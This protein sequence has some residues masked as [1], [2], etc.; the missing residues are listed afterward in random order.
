MKSLTNKIFLSTLLVCTVVI[1]GF[2]FAIMAYF[3]WFYE[4]HKIDQM[5][6]D[7]ERFSEG[8]A[9]HA[10]DE[11]TLYQ[12]VGDFMKKHNATLLVYDAESAR[13]LSGNFGTITALP[14]ERLS[15]AASEL[16]LPAQSLEPTEQVLLAERTEL[17]ALVGATTTI[18]GMLVSFSTIDR[19][20]A[21]AYMVDAAR[22]TTDANAQVQVVG[23]PDAP[24]K[25]VSI[26]KG[27]A[28]PDGS[29][30]M[31]FATASLQSVEELLQ[32]LSQL[33][34]VIALA[35]LGMSLFLAV[36]YSRMVARPI[37]TITRHAN[38]MAV[39]N[40][41][42]PIPIQGGDELGILASSLNTL[43]SELKN[44]LTSLSHSNAMLKEEYEREMKQE[45]SRKAFVANVSHELRSPLSV[46]KSYAEGICD[47]IKVDKTERYAQTIIG[48]VNAMEVMIADM[49]EISK[50]D[51]G[52][53]AFDRGAVTLSELLH[54]SLFAQ[55]S[56]IVA[57]G[58][59]IAIDMPMDIVESDGLRLQRVMDNLVENAV[60]YAREGTEIKIATQALLTSTPEGQS[61]D[62]GCG[63]LRFSIENT[64]TPFSEAELERIWERFYKRDTSHHR[65]EKGTGL[66]LSIVKSILEGLEH[67]Y[68]AVST[69]DGVRFYFEC[70]CCLAP[71]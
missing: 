31:L 12:Q 36:L 14:L 24:Y 56:T 23:V 55:Q 69:A 64:C 66:G 50:H 67:P 65:R 6:K 47:Q 57:K 1:S 42:N 32:L 59:T 18:N 41:D 58:L 34:P 68:G 38:E 45:A 54:K 63:S 40:F 4:D 35:I 25:E 15:P 17:A 16:V 28:L 5:T 13:Q 37:V 39:M 8:Y 29:S 3:N 11:G 30:K 26:Y 61:L 44:A 53:V 48:E 52:A 62:Q 21:T 2:S 9:A 70:D 10:W 22:Y 60:K 20:D 49:L 43:S 46:I 19:L 33:I 51:A 7:L 27:I 71:R